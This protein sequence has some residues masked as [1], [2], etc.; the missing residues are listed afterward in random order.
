MYQ[1]YRYKIDVNM[2]I[3]T[4]YLL[5]AIL[6]GLST[7]AALKDEMPLSVRRRLDG[8]AIYFNSDF[9]VC[10]NDS[11]TFLVNERRCVTNE[12]LINGKL[13]L[14]LALLIKP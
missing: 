8:D 11:M 10:Y 7:L 2:D 12:E 9:R 5:I 4:A 1:M 13:S 3:N 6:V 14:E